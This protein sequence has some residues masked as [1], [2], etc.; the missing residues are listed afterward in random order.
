M[1]EQESDQLFFKV[2]SFIVLFYIY[3]DNI[4]NAYQFGVPFFIS[5]LKNN[6]VLTK[7]FYKSVFVSSFY[8]SSNDIKDSTLSVYKS[9]AKMLFDQFYKE[10]LYVYTSEKGKEYL[11]AVNDYNYSFILATQQNI[12]KRHIASNIHFITTYKNIYD[13]PRISN[14]KENYESIASNPSDAEVGAIKNAKVFFVEETIEKHEPKTDLI[15]WIN[16]DIFDSGEYLLKKDKL[17]FPSE[18][19][20]EKI[21]NGGKKSKGKP[22]LNDKMLFPM[23]PI[24]IKNYPKQLSDVNINKINVFVIANFFGGTI[25]AVKQFIKDYW[26]Y[27]DYFMKK[28]DNVLVEE[29]IMGAYS[30]LN[31]EKTIFISLKDSECNSYTSSIG[32]L[33]HT[34]LCQ[35]INSLYVL[36]PGRGRTCTEGSELDTWL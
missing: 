35:F 16:I 3:Y 5:R 30:M 22:E 32:F 23:Y 13:I 10:D 34:N 28:K 15:F 14:Y 31:R 21:F 18:P 20:I 9:R 1:N 2:L 8:L 4:T 7:G 26:E 29:K 36:N 24:C 27:H 12:S 11:L 33:S 19:R 17:Y 6:I 25:D